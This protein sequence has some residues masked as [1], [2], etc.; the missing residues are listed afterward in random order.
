MITIHKI[1]A[2]EEDPANPILECYEE[3]THAEIAK[4]FAARISQKKEEPKMIYPEN[5]GQPQ[6]VIEFVPGVNAS[7]SAG[8]L[9]RVL[10][11]LG[12]IEN[13]AELPK[14]EAL[15]A[16]NLDTGVRVSV[17]KLDRALKTSGATIENRMGFKA[18]LHAKGMLV[19]SK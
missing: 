15:A 18:S 17:W 19:D 3:S 1:Q 4:L 13:S 11:R 14:I 2:V 10:D 8:Y 16:H 12:L 5:L 6:P 7:N 9:A